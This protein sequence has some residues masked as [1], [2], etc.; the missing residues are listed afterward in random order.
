MKT[1]ASKIYNFSFL[2]LAIIALIFEILPYSVRLNFSTETG[3]I[4]EY[5]SYF[6]I[7]PLGFGLFFTLPIAIFTC[8]M[9]AVGILTVFIQSNALKVI[10]CGVSLLA[11]VSAFASFTFYFSSVSFI[12]L[13]IFLL[14][15]GAFIFSFLN[16]GS[17]INKNSSL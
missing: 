17:S 6:S 4:S 7:T 2:I 12:G 5:Y 9:L 11:A 10:A 16:A 8:V 13:V 14:S 1:R 3:T 15:G